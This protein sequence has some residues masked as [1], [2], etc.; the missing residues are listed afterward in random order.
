[1]A[2]RSLEVTRTI[3]DRVLRGIYPGGMRLNEVEL[4]TSLSVSRTPVRGALSTLASEGL[5]DYTPNSGYVVH[6]YT[7][8][9]IA[10]IY[11]VRGEL[12]GLAARLAA[13]AGLNDSQRGA[14]ARVIDETAPFLRLDTFDEAAR[15]ELRDLNVRFH[16]IIYE[17]CG[18]PFLARM[19]RRTNLPILGH[20]R[21]VDFDPIALC[22]A[23]DDHVELFEAIVSRDAVR[24]DALGTEH[25]FR[26]GRRLVEQMRRREALQ[27]AG[28]PSQAAEPLKA[29]G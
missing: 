8:R 13:D 5:L 11:K 4:A 7:A 22:R 28:L 19:V 17:A 18:N 9:D 3:R 15:T 1:M 23:H 24:A 10:D 14:M 29:A 16:D 26:A 27:H 6:R 25:V 21:S 2:T 12:D 20:L